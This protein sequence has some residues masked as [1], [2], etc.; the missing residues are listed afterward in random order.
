[1]NA[2]GLAT[3]PSLIGMGACATA[4]QWARELM[5]FG[6]DVRLMSA[7][8]VAYVKRGKNDATDAAAICAAVSRPGMRFVVFAPSTRDLLI[9]PR[10]E[11]VCA[12]Q[13]FVACLTRNPNTGRTL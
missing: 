11:N 10:S 12:R 1:M 7:S 3:C 6:Y 8:Y 4:H 9:R 2:F 5:A 13:W